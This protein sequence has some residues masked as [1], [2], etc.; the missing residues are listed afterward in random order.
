MRI[1][2]CRNTR[3]RMPGK[4]T[5][6]QKRSLIDNW[7]NLNKCHLI[8]TAI[9]KWVL[10]V[11]LCFRYSSSC[12][13]RRLCRQPHQVPVKRQLIGTH[14]ARDCILIQTQKKNTDCVISDSLPFMP[15]IF[16]LHPYYSHG[17]II[18]GQG[19]DKTAQHYK[20]YQYQNSISFS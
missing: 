2:N 1:I 20:H 9:K 13:R 15:P 19:L 11:S 3:L 10:G 12:Q 17:H 8:S 6:L 14:R 18:V 5:V 4:A 16:S 7:L